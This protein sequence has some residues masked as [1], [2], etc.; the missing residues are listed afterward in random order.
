MAAGRAYR[1]CAKPAHPA[2][3]RGKIT[4]SDRD[5]RSRICSRSAYRESAGLLGK[6]LVTGRRW[7]VATPLRLRPIRSR[8]L[9]SQYA[10]TADQSCEGLA[11]I[12]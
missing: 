3:P 6:S 1:W 12:Y 10:L 11:F 8:A 5:Y 2:R 9:L 4:R 7:L